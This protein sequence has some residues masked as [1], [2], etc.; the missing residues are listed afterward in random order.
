MEVGT[1][2]QARIAAWETMS[3]WE[4]SELGK[5]LRRLG[6]SYGEIMDEI[7]VKKSTLATWCRDVKLTE[8]QYEA[9]RERRTPE[10]GRD[11]GGNGYTTQTPRRLE[12]EIIRAQ[13]KLEAIHLADDPF[14]AAGVSLYW[15]EGSK[16]GRRL[17]LANS[18][19]AALRL[20]KS[21]AERFL[22][23]NHGWSARLN[24]HADND[25]KNARA[26]WARQ[27]RVP[28]DD[29]TKSYIKPDGTGH[30][31]NHLPNGVCTL[32]KRRGTDAYHQT[33]AWVEFLRDYLW[34]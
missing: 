22:P 21:W 19:P 10:P 27:I 34:S 11:L 1:E 23:P 15:G 12:I 2:F 4:R 31:K 28:V 32:I 9:I 20:F 30:R 3:R 25:E 6:L 26:W 24:L 8:T 17:S 33:M 29:F 14:W 5:D 16:T 7:P 13:A 18:D